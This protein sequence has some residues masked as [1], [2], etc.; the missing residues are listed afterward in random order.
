M[1]MANV[2][3]PDSVYGCLH[4]YTPKPQLEGKHAILTHAS[5][6]GVRGGLLDRL[7]SDEGPWP[8]AYNVMPWSMDDAYA[9]GHG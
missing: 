7:W 5:W 4:A 2:H 6:C 1:H 9:M 3:L 8:Y